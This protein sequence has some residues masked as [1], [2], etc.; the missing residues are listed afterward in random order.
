M[1][2]SSQD[3][4]GRGGRRFAAA[5]A[6]PLLA[7]LAAVSGPVAAEEAK[8]RPHIHIDGKIG[9]KRSLGQVEALIPFAQDPTSLWFVDVRAQS[10]LDAN[11]EGSIGGGGRFIIGDTAIVG[12]YGFFDVRRTENKNFFYQATAGAEVMT[13]DFDFRFNGYLPIGDREKTFT[14]GTATSFSS[15]LD[16]SGGSIQLRTRETT[17]LSRRT[18]TALHGADA[19]FGWRLPVFEAEDRHQ[20]RAYAGAYWFD[21]PNVKQVA[22]PR[23]RLQYEL[24][25]FAGV[26]DTSRLVLG[27]EVQHDDVR[28]TQAF[29]FG[30]LSL[31]LG[32]PLGQVYADLGHDHASLGYQVASAA[33]ANTVATDAIDPPRTEVAQATPQV[34]DRRRYYFDYSTGRYVRTGQPLRPVE[35]RAP[36]RYQ[37]QPRRETWRTARL[38]PLER[39]MVEPVTRDVDI[40][41]STSDPVSTSTSRTFNEDVTIIG[42]NVDLTGLGGTRV[43]PGDDLRTAVDGGTSVLV[44][45]GTH[46]INANLDINDDQYVIGGGQRV[47]GKISGNVIEIGQ[48]GAVD[49][50]VAGSYVI[51]MGD[52]SL[53]QNLTVTNA[54]TA[55]GSHGVV[56]PGTSNEV[57]V[58][59]NT[60]T[61]ESGSGIRTPS[62]SSHAL[63]VERNRVTAAGDNEA[64]IGL[65]SSNVV[66]RRNVVEFEGMNGAGIS[67][68]GST[69]MIEGN[70]VSTEGENTDG[71]TTTGDHGVIRRNVVTVDGRTAANQP[72]LFA[73]GISL[74]GTDTL[75]FENEITTVSTRGYAMRLNN[76]VGSVISTN[77]ID[78]DQSVGDGIFLTGNSHGTTI[79]DNVFL[80]IGSG[81]YV[82]EIDDPP[83]VTPPATPNPI[84][85]VRGGGNRL[86]TD[87]SKVCVDDSGGVNDVAFSF[88]SEGIS[89]SNLRGSLC[90]L[91]D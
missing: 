45:E 16:T 38:T 81:G 44:V 22:G 87:N 63:I 26:G 79:T 67:L 66:I 69:P 86:E 7:A 10:D 74:T 76:A 13:V 3:G 43:G 46:S 30:R 89:I 50:N 75:L 91:D 73:D 72:S 24:H 36:Q 84:T 90:R 49:G 6:V 64:G 35:V 5:V 51:G 65:A 12:G 68:T 42:S 8:W 70:T 20:F 23:G 28:D 18:E 47:R 55:P 39:R 59:D 19:E 2:T 85:D 33:P 21:G 1:R 82:I 53:L 11:I 80:S 31:P 54:N 4:V 58:S 41:T 62:G 78:A 27:V 56:V 61:V 40:V 77:T 25:G 9:T 29:G 88:V 60:I 71:I 57:T 32:R 14:T 34:R 15:S 52:G 17:T 37:P 83:P 48:P